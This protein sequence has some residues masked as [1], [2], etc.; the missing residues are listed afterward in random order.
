MIHA[1][2]VMNLK[3][4]MPNKR[5]QPQKFTNYIIPFILGFKKK[6]SYSDGDTSVCQDFV[7]RGGCSYKRAA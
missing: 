6:Q 7:V 4:I 2:T 1:T 3:G 5:N